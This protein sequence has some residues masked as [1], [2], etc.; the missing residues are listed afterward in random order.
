MPVARGA[1]RTPERPI[2]CTDQPRCSH[3]IPARLSAMLG[4]RAR[5][6]RWYVRDSMRAADSTLSVAGAALTVLLAC[7]SSPSPTQGGAAAK[8][9]TDDCPAHGGAC[10]PVG[11]CGRGQGHMGREACL[12]GHDTVCCFPRACA[13]APRRSRDAPAAPPSVS[14]ART[15]S[16]SA[17]QIKRKSRSGNAGGRRL[18]SGYASDDQG[19]KA[20]KQRRA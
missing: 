16:R 18:Q 8:V 2:R 6:P 14:R 5:P 12:E 1:V 13:A 9:I 17:R 10:V 15:A 19:A 3:P 11:S 7:A 20:R 4:R